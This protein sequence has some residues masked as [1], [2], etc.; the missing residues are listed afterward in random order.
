MPGNK[1]SGRKRKDIES[2]STVSN[3]SSEAPTK[4][5]PG[6]PRKVITD[7][8]VP[9]SDCKS[10]DFVPVVKEAKHSKLPGKRSTF[11][12]V[13]THVTELSSRNSEL[14]DFHDKYVGVALNSFPW[15]HFPLKRTILQRYRALRAESH[16]VAHSDLVSIITK[17]VI[18]LWDCS[19]IPHIDLKGCTYQ[20]KRLISQW[21]SA[22]KDE[23]TSTLYQDNLNKLLDLRPPS[24]STLP[25]LRKE[26][27]KL[28]GDE[29]KGKEEYEFFKGQLKYPQKDLMSPSREG[30]EQAK[31]KRKA[32]RDAKAM[33]YK[34]RNTF[35]GSFNSS[36]NTSTT[37]SS[38]H[39]SFENFVQDSKR[40]SAIIATEQI[41]RCIR[42][43]ADQEY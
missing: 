42:D 28:R 19:A 43:S 24:L 37:S 2:T 6:R 25:A 15:K 23:K 16:N 32:E 8:Q 21:V 17:E 13:A 1:T 3:E 33:A 41:H 10:T 14:N 34:E 20:V 40:D 4:Q 7:L 36:S 18:E 22:R 30:A 27:N 5:K 39:I 29:E 9:S 38:K 35:T 26:L 12:R 11:D 31:S